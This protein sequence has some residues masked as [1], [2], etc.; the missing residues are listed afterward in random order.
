MET[1]LALLNVLVAVRTRLGVV[2]NPVLRLLVLWVTVISCTLK[3][4]AAET[5]VPRNHVFVT[6]FK[7]T[8]LAV[9]MR[10]RLITVVVELTV[11]TALAETPSEVFELAYCVE[12]KVAIVSRLWVSS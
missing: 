10:V 4:L 3:L 5:F 1:G 8:L 11:G 7:G 6:H 9:N 2:G 12:V